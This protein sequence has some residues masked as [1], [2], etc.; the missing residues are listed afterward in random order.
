MS[1]LAKP[2]DIS[3]V[4]SKLEV[5]KVGGTGWTTYNVLLKSGEALEV[6]N[7]PTN[8]T[9]AVGENITCFFGNYDRW[10]FKYEEDA[11]PKS[12]GKAAY[13]KPYA[14]EA[15]KQYE[16]PKSAYQAKNNDRE[17]YWQDKAKYE[18][19]KR[20]PKIEFQSYLGQVVNT[21]AAAIP[22]LEEPPKTPAEIDSLI[23]NAFDKAKAIY[24]KV[25]PKVK[26]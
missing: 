12:A 26:E 5:K 22:T 20:D 25:N 1:E 14:K 8:P 21:Y 4:I 16:P 9:P 19:E 2:D 23:D 18:E 24:L 13:S 6:T 11:A 7:K 15:P 17:N 3:G 10:Y